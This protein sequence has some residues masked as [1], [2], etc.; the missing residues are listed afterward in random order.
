M[1]NVYALGE[2]L[3]TQLGELDLFLDKEQ[4]LQELG[5]SLLTSGLF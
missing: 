4:T 3:T 1:K 5:T 2:V